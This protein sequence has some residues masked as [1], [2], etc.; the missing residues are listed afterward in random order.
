LHIWKVYRILIIQS[1]GMQFYFEI[2][3]VM[4][5]SSMLTHFLYLLRVWR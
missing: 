4:S 5:V 3:W 1:I 2:D